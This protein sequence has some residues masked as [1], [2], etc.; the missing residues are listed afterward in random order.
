[1]WCGTSAQKKLC[2]F[3]WQIDA[4]EHNGVIM[5]TVEPWML[6]QDRKLHFTPGLKADG[7]DERFK[8]YQTF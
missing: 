5:F 4:A 7:L 6:K 8:R 2:G 3:P 1:M